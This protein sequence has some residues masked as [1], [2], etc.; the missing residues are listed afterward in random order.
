MLSC[1]SLK[2]I[3]ALSHLPQLSVSYPQE[4][5]V[6]LPALSKSRANPKWLHRCRESTGGDVGVT[7]SGSFLGDLVGVSPGLTCKS[8]TAGVG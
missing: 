5:S 8:T 7:Q 4:A 3:V 1:A 6:R 2:G